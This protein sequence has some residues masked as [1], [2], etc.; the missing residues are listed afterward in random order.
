M[1]LVVRSIT[2]PPEND[3]RSGKAGRHRMLKCLRSVCTVLLITAAFPAAAW[4]QM[5]S[6]SGGA[7][8]GAPRL[9]YSQ[10]DGG[11]GRA[12]YYGGVYRGVGAA[13]PRGIYRNG[14]IAGWRRS[15]SPYWGWGVAA[16]LLATAPTYY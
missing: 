3:R 13:R 5:H 8:V 14:Y 15:F 2:L 6:S 12:L 4:A 1:R 10:N 9:S 16:G 7:R 11:P